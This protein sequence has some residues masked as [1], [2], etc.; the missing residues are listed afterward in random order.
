MGKRKPIIE[1]VQIV[2]FGHKGLTIGKTPTGEAVLVEDAVPGDVVNYQVRRKKKGMKLGH[3]AEF[4]EKSKH[5]VEPVCAHFD[6]CGGCSWQNLDY[7]EQCQQK[8]DIVT[9]AVHRIG[10]LP[11]V[12]ILPIIGGDPQYYYRNK[13]EYTFANKRWLTVEEISSGKIYT[14]GGL[15]FHKAGL[16]DKVVNIDTCHLQSEPSN[17]IRNATR[18]WASEHDLSYYDYKNHTGQLRN[19][20]IRLTRDGQVM[21]ILVT[22]TKDRDIINSF[23]SFL[24]VQ[25]PE[26]KNLVWMINTKWNDALHDVPFE[27]ITGPGYIMET[28]DGVKFKIGPKSF[29]QTNPYQAEV[30]FRA[31]KEA[32]DLKST[33]TLYDLYCGVGSIGLYMAHSCKKVVGVEGIPEAIEDA[34]M[35]AALNGFG[36]AHF[37]V[38]DVGALVDE[39]FLEMH[40]AADVVVTDPPRAGMHENVVKTLIAA[41]V[42]KLVYVSCNPATQARDLKLLSEVYDVISVQPVDMFPQT[43]HVESIAILKSRS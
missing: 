6:V 38:G 17:A 21:V 2:S 29:F 35:N 5:R 10:Q 8:Q 28:L 3:V 9:N 34:K 1:N 30:L 22:A 16:F 4:V 27:V 43:N 14:E 24:A 23:Q 37:E 11:E 19:L 33:D 42:P 32:A 41:K 25:F 18:K 26:V 40:G 31:V 39:S 13:V 12:P 20:I 15:G 7:K 36:N